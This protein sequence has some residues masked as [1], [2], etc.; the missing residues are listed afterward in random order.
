MALPLLLND[1]TPFPQR[2]SIIFLACVV[3]FVTLVVQGLSLPLLIRLLKIKPQDNAE[4]EEKEL[5]LYLAT[6]T[7]DFIEKELKLELKEAAQQELRRKY[8]TMIHELTKDIKRH[9]KAKRNDMPVVPKPPDEI[10]NAKLEIGKFQRELLLKLHKE[11]EFSDTA[12]KHIE[13]EMD[14]DELKLNLQ[15]PK[16]EPAPEV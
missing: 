5:K 7:L 6:H 1:G 9:K 12:I 4:A 16:D 15:V 8:E 3:I 11:A 2:Q 13:R 10:L 14:I